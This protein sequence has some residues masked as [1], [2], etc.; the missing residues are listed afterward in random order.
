MKVKYLILTILTFL[1]AGCEKILF[2]DDVPNTPENNYEMFWNDFNIYYPF[3]EI[4]NIDWDA[5]NSQYKPMVTS[6]TS[7][8]EL[9]GILSEMIQPFKDGHVQLFSQYGTSYFYP[10]EIFTDYFSNMKI[11]PQNYLNFFESDN[12]NIK[13]AN[14]ISHNIGY[15]SINTFKGQDDPFVF[16]SASFLIID[17][18]VNQFKNKDGIIIDVRWNGGGFQPNAETI[19]NRFTKEERLYVKARSKNGPCKNDFSDWFDWYIEPEGDYQFTKPVVVLTSRSTG[20]TAEWFTLMMKTLSNVKIVGDTT[21]GSFSQH[22]YRELPNG[23]SFSLSTTIVATANLT[24][25]EGVGISPDY[26]I[27]NTQSDIDNKT[28]AMLEKGI[29]VI[30]TV[31]K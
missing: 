4:K 10:M 12:S 3:F 6:Q 28:D 1:F 23:W 31:V 19:A 25:Y 24:V 21:N 7:S 11:N 30:E 20:N 29:E 18:I 27:L 8:T 22:I 13:Y 5:V 14:V 17:D 16:S 26:Y 2:E 9:F 15:I